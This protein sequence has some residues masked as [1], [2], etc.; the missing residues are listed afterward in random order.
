MESKVANLILEDINIEIIQKKIKNIY[1][2]VHRPAG[3]VKV[4]APEKMSLDAIKAFVLSKLPWIKKQKLKF[5][6]PSLL[7]PKTFM[8]GESH[9]FNG[10]HY[11]LRIIKSE[12][13][14]KVLLNDTEIM[15]YIRPGWEIIHKKALL[16]AWYGQELNLKLASL[17]P[18]WEQK[19]NVS[20]EKFSLRKMKTK[21]GSCS[22][23]SRTIR[24]NL[25]LVKKPFEC[26]EYVVVHELA[27][28]IEA[29]HNARFKSLMDKF[30]PKWRLHRE[31]LNRFPREI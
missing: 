15:L 1:L 13:A 17:I 2:G 4:T 23:L 24:F 9:Y 7:L 18:I 30:L 20:V 10:M 27:H 6:N 22:P 19:M 3:L 25:E 29:S 5:E 21:W 16:D 12:G 31:E 11:M 26:L 28:L 8:D 14:P